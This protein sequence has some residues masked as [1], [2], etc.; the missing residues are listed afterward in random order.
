[1]QVFLC[2]CVWIFLFIT[3]FL[4][5]YTVFFPP[6]QAMKFLCFSKFS[7]VLF[8]EWF[9]SCLRFYYEIYKSSSI[10][11][12]IFNGTLWCCAQ[13]G[14]ASVAARW[15]WIITACLKKTKQKNG[16]LSYKQ[17]SLRPRWFRLLKQKAKQKDWKNITTE[18]CVYVDC[19]FVATCWL[20]YYSEAISLIYNTEC[21]KNIF[22]RF[23]AVTKHA[24]VCSYFRHWIKHVLYNFLHFIYLKFHIYPFLSFKILDTV[25]ISFYYYIFY[26]RQPDAIYRSTGTYMRI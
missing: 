3:F 6:S 13:W 2:A 23:A 9:V 10:F 7:F 20:E 1:M 8:N 19:M 18:E 24:Y 21:R 12:D 17:L 16:S 26:T 4:H 5:L 14:N 15:L 11:P 25:V 22:H